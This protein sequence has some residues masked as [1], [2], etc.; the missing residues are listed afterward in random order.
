MDPAAWN[1]M[2]TSDFVLLG[3]WAPPPLR[4]LLWA[5]LLAAY[6][7]T[8]LGNG[9]LGGLIA[10]DQRLHWPMCRLLAPL[11][12]LGTAYVSTTLSQVLVH[13]TARRA[14]LSPARCGAQLYLGISL[15][16]SPALR[17]DHD[18][19]ALCPPGHHRVALGFLL[20]VPNAA[21]AL[22]L[23]FCPGR[24]PVDHFPCELPAVLKTA[25]ADTAADHVLVYGLG[26]PILLVPL[27]FILASYALILAAV[28][29][30]PSA[31]SRLKALSTC[32]SHLAVVGLFYG[33]VTAMYLRPRGS[34]ALPAK[35]H[36]LVAVFCLV[37]TPVLNPL[38]YS[39]RNREVNAA[40]ATPLPGSRGRAL[41]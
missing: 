29:Q 2:G 23:P 16:S 20:S 13:V 25:C 14:T 3:L 39:L 7:A 8:V 6:L 40:A 12:L 21:A 11:A 15:G 18:A 34:S 26:T 35:R 32:S 41:C 30:L 24:P 33:T 22:R 27:A 19:R 31:K 9:T 17:G 1:E 4:P 10:L 5:A 36:K 38:I 28:G 37:I